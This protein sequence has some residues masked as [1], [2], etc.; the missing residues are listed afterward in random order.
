MRPQWLS[1]R[2]EGKI[3]ALRRCQPPSRP[4]SPKGP[5]LRSGSHRQIPKNRAAASIRDRKRLCCNVRSAVVSVWHVWLRP[6]VSQVL[7]PR[8]LMAQ[9]A[10]VRRDGVLW[11]WAMALYKGPLGTL[12]V[13]SH[14]ES[15]DRWCAIFLRAALYS[16]PH[17]RVPGIPGLDFGRCGTPRGSSPIHQGP[18]C[19]R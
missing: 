14:S 9:L 13:T 15:M 7:V 4:T 10:Q 2:Q 19:G 6:V 16:P 8:R 17:S 11:L 3:W 18:G 1:D 12:R 5:R